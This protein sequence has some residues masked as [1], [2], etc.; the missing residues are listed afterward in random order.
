MW[1]GIA[2]GHGAPP[3]QQPRPRVPEADP[4]RKFLRQMPPLQPDRTLSVLNLTKVPAHC[5]DLP[6]AGREHAETVERKQLLNTPSRQMS[7]LPAIGLNPE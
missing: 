7:D 1:I 6:K 3:G 4:G 2:R 5:V